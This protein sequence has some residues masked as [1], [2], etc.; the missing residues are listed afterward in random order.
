MAT[1]LFK[2]NHKEL[3]T[4][5]DIQ[6]LKCSYDSNYLTTIPHEFDNGFV[7]ASYGITCDNLRQRGCKVMGICYNTP[8]F[9]AGRNC[10]IVYKGIN[11]EEEGWVHINEIIIRAWTNEVED[12][13]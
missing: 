6:A 5:E 8:W 12:N 10:A 3:C 2:V 7:D 13:V 1:P 9:H 4:A 11:T